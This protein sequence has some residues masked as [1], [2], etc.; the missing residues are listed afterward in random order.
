MATKGNFKKLIKEKVTPAL[1]K[2]LNLKNSLAVPTFKKIEVNVGIGSYLAG[3]KDYSNVVENI[4]LI[5]GQ[6]PVITKA[7][8]AISNFKLR[9]GM[10]V[11]VKVTL[12][13]EKMY[14]FL[15]KLINISLISV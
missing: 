15:D 1:Q 10:P 9:T 8:M 13:R 14:D 3:S 5:T 12:R 11:G 4:K 6:M 7:R 2:K